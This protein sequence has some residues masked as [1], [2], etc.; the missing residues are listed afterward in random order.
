MSTSGSRPPA[1]PQRKLVLR[2][3]VSTGHAS[4]A[5]P[6]VGAKDLASAATPPPPTALPRALRPIEHPANLEA[7]PK[8]TGS[9]DSGVGSRSIAGSK[10]AALLTPRSGATPL[11]LP[12]RISVAPVVASVPTTW[13]AR[14]RPP[15]RTRG[16]LALRAGGGLLVAGAL[17]ATG[18]L[19]STRLQFR[20]DASPTTAPREV[21]HAAAPSPGAGDDMLRATS[22]SDHVTSV[23]DLPRASPPARPLSSGALRSVL[24]APLGPPSAAVVRA[25]AVTPAEGSEAAA[26]AGAAGAA[27]AAAPGS[28]P[29]STSAQVPEVQVPSVP[30]P[31][32]DPLIRAV[33]QSIDDGHG[34]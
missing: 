7:L 12:S 19:L 26:S 1:Q 9:A 34:N 11:P 20:P 3:K 30:P 21:I 29:E 17:M 25:L 15:A 31:P 5:P 10:A 18:V 8:P 23:E 4:Q 6:P 33:Q 32:A 22:R 24:R 28:A 27:A 13:P 14:P 16:R 2:R